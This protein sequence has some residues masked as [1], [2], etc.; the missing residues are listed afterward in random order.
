MPAALQKATPGITTHPKRQPALAQSFSSLLNQLAR[1]ASCASNMR[2]LLQLLR[3]SAE[4]RSLRFAAG[5]VTDE[6]IRRYVA[7][8][9]F[10]RD[11]VLGLVSQ[12]GSVFGLVHGCVFTAGGR[13]HVEAAFSID[14]AWRGH[15]LATSLMHALTARVAVRAD[16]AG[17]TIVGSCAAR[18]L[19]MRAVFSHAGMTLRR[20]EDEIHALGRVSQAAASFVDH[21]VVDAV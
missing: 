5:L 19:P 21:V 1:L 2:S 16:A 7:A 13:S 20:E 15:G 9:P 4:D 6:S 18:N 12:R 10:E 11:L 14:A 17:A 3:L 8:I